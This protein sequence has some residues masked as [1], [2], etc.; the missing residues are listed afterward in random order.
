MY[1]DL[2]KLFFFFVLIKR[3]AGG[4]TWEES[5]KATQIKKRKQFGEK[6]A[7]KLKNNYSAMLI[8][9]VYVCYVN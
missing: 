9:N 1:T 4:K 7:K 8:A 3:G 2:L 6:I 5:L